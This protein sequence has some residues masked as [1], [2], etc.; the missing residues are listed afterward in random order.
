MSKITTES[1]YN[2][3]KTE[4]YLTEIKIETNKQFNDMLKL[5]DENRS[6]LSYDISKNYDNIMYL[7]NLVEDQ[8]KVNK[9]LFTMIAILA[10][11]VCCLIGY[12]IIRFGGM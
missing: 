7:L 12:I 8:K 10:C 2:R 4:E 3:K 6:D 9:E 5:I 11:V 1:E